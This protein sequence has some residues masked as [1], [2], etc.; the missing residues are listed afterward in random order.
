MN[1][2][3]IIRQLHL[4]VDARL[5][6]RPHGRSIE[7]VRIDFRQRSCGWGWW[8]RCPA[9]PIRCAVLLS[10]TSF[11]W[12]YLRSL[13]AFGT[14][15]RYL[16]S[17]SNTASSRN[18]RFTACRGFSTQVRVGSE[19]LRIMY[20]GHILRSTTLLTHSVE[21]SIMPLRGDPVCNRYYGY[22]AP[23]SEP[24]FYRRPYYG[25]DTNGGHQRH[26]NSARLT[27]PVTSATS[28]CASSNSAARCIGRAALDPSIAQA[29]RCGRLRRCA[30][31]R[32]L[33]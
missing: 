33:W 28:A 30:T 14:N 16:R 31:C 10:E 1:R 13:W 23:R 20:V 19:R 5:S 26:Q 9:K 27:C 29:C 17:S 8:K 4:I 32:R 3:E 25:G 22:Y 7:R 24:G 2:N 15:G 12:T 6:E 21:R 18:R 11:I